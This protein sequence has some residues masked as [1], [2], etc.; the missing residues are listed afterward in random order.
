MNALKQRLS[1]SIWAEIRLDHIWHNLREV[2]KRLQ[3]RVKFMA[4]VKANGYGH[5][6]VQAA[7]AAV[8]AKADAL[9]VSALE[10]G[11]LLRR[12]GITVPILIL[13][14]IAPEEINT[15]T[16]HGLDLTVFQVSWLKEMRKFK[17][18]E[19]PV[20]I[21]I[22]M[23]TG[24]GRWGLG[25]RSEFEA[26][27]PLLRAK[28]ICVAGVY[29]HFAAANQAESSYTHQ[30]F[31]RF[32][33][34]RL[35]LEKAGFYGVVAHCANSAVA[36]RFPEY[37]MDMVRVGASLFGIVPLD[38]GVDYDPVSLKPTMSLY[39]VIKH[40]KRVFPGQ[41]VSYDCSYIAQ[42]EEWIATLPIGYAD[43]WFRG[44]Q[45]MQ[46]LINDAW[47]PIVGK[48]CMNQ[49]MVRLPK[50]VPVGTKVTLIGSGI[51][52]DHL[53]LHIGSIPQQVL[54]MISDRV[55]RIWLTL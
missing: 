18:D 52:L 45:G 5:G 42:E 30:Q 50:Y 55:P 6:M 20:T 49:T 8:A 36:I 34:M 15:A 38:P 40:V 53:A 41:T 3:A 25:K 35:W 48:I 16:E 33:A 51:T 47:A 13:S 9:A 22:K 24:M 37:A 46:V 39:T 26:M 14:P 21:H 11:V 31:R 10:E 1:D 27:V 7:Q 12:E 2:R 32:R 19:K 54:A 43:G 44:Y 17:R 23:D 4:V 28:D 29:T